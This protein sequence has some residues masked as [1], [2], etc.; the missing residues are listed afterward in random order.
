MKIRIFVGTGGVGKTSVTAASALKAA[1]DGSRCLVLTIDPALRLRAA[2]GMSSTAA[3]QKVPLGSNSLKGELWAALLDIRATMDRMVRVHA[4]RRQAET[5]LNDPVYRFLI[6]SVAGM[7]ELMAIERIDQAMTDGF[8]TIFIDTAPSR[9]A[10][11]FLDKPE[12]FAQLVTS[13]VVQLMGRTYKW[14]ERSP[15][16]RLNRKS[17]ELYSRVEELVGATLV[18]QILD[19]FSVFQTVAEN[20]ASRAKHTISLL[21][22]PR[23]TTFTIVTTPFKCKQDSDYLWG[24]LNKRKFF[25]E[26]LVVNRLW[27]N[28]QPNLPPKAPPVA[29]DLV[30]WY[31]SVYIAQQDIW[32]KVSASSSGKIPK[33]IGLPELPRDIDGLT[34]LEH[35]AQHM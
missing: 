27:P 20:Y 1:L 8:E 32:N 18:R 4:K 21:R 10:F 14:W 34:A 2:L 24:E 13:P 5:V 17:F 23:T 19:F 28:L 22:D 26:T 31:K 33:L 16:A 30:N 25:V 12:F 35:M 11:E 29:R 9:H 15:I 7:N 3:Q 6:T